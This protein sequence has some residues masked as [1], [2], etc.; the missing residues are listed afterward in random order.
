M[1]EVPT[2][3]YTDMMMLVYERRAKGL[4]DGSHDPE[5]DARADAEAKRKGIPAMYEKA[6]KDGR[7][8]ILPKV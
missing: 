1:N 2:V 7:I 4:D 8:V 5:R 3:S 6:I